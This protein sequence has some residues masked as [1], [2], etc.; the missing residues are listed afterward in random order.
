M[1][2][3]GLFVCYAVPQEMQ[4]PPCCSAGFSRRTSRRLATCTTCSRLKAGFQLNHVSPVIPEADDRFVFVVF[5]AQSA[6]SGRVEMQAGA[7]AAIEPAPARGQHPQKV[8]TRKNQDVARRR[9]QAGD[10]PV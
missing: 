6:E 5:I 8:A 7:L 2:M 9:S 1:E 3:F 4:S 10:D